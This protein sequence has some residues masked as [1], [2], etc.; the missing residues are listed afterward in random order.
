MD[1]IVSD[2]FEKLKQSIKNTTSDLEKYITLLP[3]FDTLKT[4]L[5]KYVN[6]SDLSKFRDR[7]INHM[8]A[9]R[10]DVNIMTKV[11]KENY[12]DGVKLGT[13]YNDA[14]AALRGFAESNLNSAVVLSAGLNPSL[15][16][17]MENFDD[18][19]CTESGEIKKQIVLKVSDFKSAL[20][21]GK[22]FA[23]K[24]LW[25]S[26]YRIESGL[27]CGGHAFATDGLLMGPILEDFKTRK[28]ELINSAFELLV[29]ALVTKNKYVPTQAPELRITAQGGVGTSDEHG[30]LL[31]YYQLDK[32]GW[33]S[34]FLLVPEVTDIDSETRELLINAKEDDLY[35]SNISPLGV[36]FN[37]IRGNSK[38][39]LKDLQIANGTPGA[40]CVK[41]Y[42]QL[43][44]EFS[45]RGLCTASNAYQKLKIA[46]LNEMAIS[47]SEY[48][49]K[50]K[51][52]TDRAC[53]CVGLGTASLLVN[54]LNSKAEGPGVS[55]CPGPNIA[56]FSDVY[57]LKSMINHIYGRTDLIQDTKRPHMFLKEL[58]LYIN[59]LKNK[60]SDT[61]NQKS[62][63]SV[64]QLS[65]FK[66]NL[67]NGV[68][69]YQSLY[70]QYKTRLI[71]IRSNFEKELLLLK[72]KLE[73]V[74][75]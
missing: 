29:P 56:Y 72:S 39:K 60:I 70:N 14:H 49:E 67:L 21:Q 13:E 3:D 53:I 68:D 4:D 43:N 64:K 54:N 35:L 42:V 69:Y 2:N 51:Q 57:S 5:I 46:E 36:P 65:Q 30:F 34:P 61:A 11:D 74:H 33:G 52:I 20:I 58:D 22:I 19:Y 71:D 16:S 24:G 18:F 50:H 27:N 40:V 8:K 75:I 17:Y 28:N 41:K 66:I 38:D 9:G 15:Y 73:Q 32:V 48:A 12:S 37:N 31:D 59:Y 47:S 44:K 10:I 7:V 26:E 45:D 55:V 1:K 62:E 6:E 23:K 63:K 25:V